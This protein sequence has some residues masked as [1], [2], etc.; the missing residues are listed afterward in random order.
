MVGG[1]EGNGRDL[2]A[3]DPYPLDV[4]SLIRIV[5]VV[6]NREL[7]IAENRFYRIVVRALFR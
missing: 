3:R 1:A 6:L 4:S 5:A 2:S 7:D